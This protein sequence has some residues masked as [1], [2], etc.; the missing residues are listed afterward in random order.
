MAQQQAKFVEGSTMRHILT[1][2]GAGS[3]GLMSLFIVDLL[4]MMFISMLGQIE[5]AAAVGFAGTIIFFSTSISIGTSIAM[6]ALVSKELGAKRV[7]SA[8]HLVINVLVTAFLVNAVITGVMTYYIP[9]LLQLIGAKGAAFEHAKD[10]M[11]ILLPSTP[12]VALGMAAGAA[13][14]AAG[15]AKRSMMATIW[16]GVVNAILDPIFIFVFMW[17]VEG[18]ALAS[19]VSRFTVLAFS[20]APLIK[21]HDLVGKFRY[22]QWLISQRAIF[23]IALPA[24][25]TNIATPIGNAIVTSSIA[26]YGEDFV[27]GFAVV[28]R[29]TPVVF[30]A[31]FALSGAVGPIIGQNY[32]A[33]RIDRVKETL[34][35]SLIVVS[36]YCVTVSL[37]LY[38][39]QSFIVSGFNLTGDADVLVRTFC[40]FVAVTFLFN[41]AQFVANTSFNNLGKPLYS[42]A[43]NVGKATVGTIP[44]V[45]IGSAWF[46]ALGV[47]YG[48]AVG[49]IVFGLIALAALRFHVH[50]LNK[51][52]AVE[53]E[54]DEGLHSVNMQPFCTHDAVVMEE[55]AKNDELVTEQ[56]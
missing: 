50:Q 23:A 31:I 33:D 41:G 53:D 9:E 34:L 13:L 46:G 52:A 24:I 10:Y 6:G 26:Q 48:Q 51:E 22:K 38:F 15:D 54:V 42:T 2:S 28:G 32:G 18:A 19:V 12:I 55:L 5:L 47:L 29:L 14:R 1:M 25:F 8:R 35:N 3:I 37:V 21:H 43:L 30:A 20:L 7:Q 40:T 16:G 36:I 11:Y 49:N 27:A 56:K 4:D 44:F 45:Y 39:L 17:N